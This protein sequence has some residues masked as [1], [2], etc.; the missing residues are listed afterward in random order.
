MT[1]FIHHPRNVDQAFSNNT[2]SNYVLG[3]VAIAL[4]ILWVF[5]PSDYPLRV[6]DTTSYLRFDPYRG[7]GYPFF[8]Q[9]TQVFQLDW[10]L[11]VLL[12]L[13]LFF[14]TLLYLSIS[15]KRFTS[16]FV[17]GV[18]LLV[19][20][21]ANPA[22]VQYCFSL[23]T[24]SL[25]FSS[26][27]LLTGLILKPDET[28]NK[29]RPFLIGCLVA[30]L[31]LIKPVSWALVCIPV[32]LMV[33][34][35]LSKNA[36]FKRTSLIFLGITLVLSAGTLYR[37]SVHQSWIPSSFMGNQ[38]TGKLVFS[39]FDAQKTPYPT[40][41]K[42]WLALTEQSR[43]ARTQHMHSIN[44][45]FVFSLNIYDYLRFRKMPEVLQ[46]SN[47]P[48][49]GQGQALNV[50]AYSIIKQDPT[51]YLEDV[52]INFYGLWALAELQSENMIREYNRKL[53][54]V[55]PD[56]PDEIIPYRPEPQN[57]KTFIGIKLFLAIAAIANVLIIFLGLKQYLTRFRPLPSAGLSLFL[58]A[59][60]VQS[61][62][63]L[64]ASLQAGL[65]RYAI[66]AWPLHLVLVIAGAVFFFDHYFG[67][68]RASD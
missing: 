50:L 37:F 36:F 64:T 68:S 11:V 35:L 61:Y 67:K 16:S 7:A 26:L 40:A 22:V 52:M 23:I 44:E 30:W 4:L 27:M 5:F 51:G 34:F 17:S 47:I 38:L 12:Q 18:A 25:F 53:E 15:L 33:Q 45:K 56:L 21:G 28:S 66:A 13:A 20:T 59:V 8:L 24:E 3:L 55:K 42:H 48:E 57:P 14:S 46:K 9:L 41:G 62:F 39:E 2:I 29:A 6:P 49:S 54:L 43:K 58:V 31:I 65:M 19:G 10:S 60:M 1:P 63:L 32:I